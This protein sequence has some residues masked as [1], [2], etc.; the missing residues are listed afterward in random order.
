[1]IR[2]R[3]V[4]ALVVVSILFLSI[5]YNKFEQS[6]FADKVDNI[7]LQMKNQI[8]TMVSAYEAESK[9]LVKM[10]QTL[11][12][13]GTK[14]IN[15]NSMAPYFAAAQ[16]NDRNQLVEW[17]FRE[18]SPVSSL[19]KESITQVV[20]SF[21]VNPES[22]Q[23]AYHFYQDQEK[24]RILMTLVPV[25]DKLW[26]FVSLGES[27][28]NLMDNQ[29]TQSAS[30]ALV[31]RD[32][33]SVAHVKPEY[34]GQ[35]IFENTVIKDLRESNKTMTS[36]S[37][38]ITSG[39]EFFAVMEKIPN[40]ELYLYT[41]TSLSEIIKSKSDFRRQFAFFSFGFLFILVG[42]LFLLVPAESGTTESRASVATSA[43]PKF[44]PR[45]EVTAKIQIPV[46]P[47]TPEQRAVVATE[48]VKDRTQSN[49]RIASALGHEMKAPLVKILSLVQIGN[50]SES[51]EEMGKL[52]DKVK[53]EARAANEIIDK[54][55]LFA[56]EK[57]QVKINTK[58]DTPLLR[59]VKNLE[60]L[61]FQKVVKITKELSVTD[62][63]DMDVNQMITVF[64]NVLRNSIQ[65]LDRKSNKEIKIKTYSEN[66][67]VMVL[68]EDN[69]EGIPK[70]ISEKIF[71]P[72]FTSMN[73]GQ[74]MGLGLTVALGIV[75]QH[76]GNVKV[77][78]ERGKGAKVIIEFV[79][80]AAVKTA[81]K[82][83]EAPK[84]V[85]EQQTQTIT[86]FPPAPPREE[87]PQKVEAEDDI[88]II[89]DEGEDISDGRSLPPPPKVLN[90]PKVQ[91]DVFLRMGDEKLEKS[92][93]EE[94]KIKEVI[95]H[96][97]EDNEMFQEL[98]LSQK[99]ISMKPIDLNVDVDE[100]FAMNNEVPKEPPKSAPTVVSPEPKV[101]MP[102]AIEVKPVE[103]P[104]QELGAATVTTTFITSVKEAA[105][106][107]KDR[108]SD[109]FKVNI[110]K[111][112]RPV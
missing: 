4:I 23:I 97:N 45:N 39:E 2:I 38:S 69:G 99:P 48:N 8:S 84:V 54:L 102:K 100:L 21:Q 43:K 107:K 6:L 33:V 52:M 67:K 101:E 98:N 60:A 20:R 35:K 71:D 83:I 76:N 55:L 66:G 79:P 32:L 19:S 73:V 40:M 5:V 87:M 77:E 61:C 13:E 90:I 112:G 59:A 64:E 92:E 15:W 51:K 103:V 56:G 89:D 82:A 1:M 106:K 3:V 9:F 17:F 29:K 94:G 46:P 96:Q 50:F 91:D 58:I 18:S 65:A 44:D 86:K 68:I 47:S 25:N 16:L 53:S 78:S 75:K 49:M 85:D 62:S 42:V 109:N 93:D 80:E 37:F 10:A 70:E 31:N 110:R 36:G 81:K 28:Q 30:L 34:I 14:R 63:F 72:F 74:H 22:K 111:P 24:K 41:Q 95:D 57:E 27:L 11:T 7:E 26:V 104:S 88:I 12:A 108:A 105:P